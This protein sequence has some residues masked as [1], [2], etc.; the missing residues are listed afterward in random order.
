M[1][2]CE[3]GRPGGRAP[4]TEVASDADRGVLADL[5]AH[6]SVSD[7]W[8][9]PTR[10]VDLLAA[11]RVRLVALTDHDTLDGVAAAAARALDHGVGFVV[12]V[13]IT[14]APRDGM[15]HVLAHGVRRDDSALAALLTRNRRVWRAESLAVLA[16]LR[17]V[18]LR[19]RDRPEYDDPARLLMPHMIARDAVRQGRVRHAEIWRLIDQARAAV[20]ARV[21]AALPDPAETVATVHG[22]GGLAVWAHPGRSA[23]PTAM[24]RSVR[25]FDG[26]E[27]YTPRHSPAEVAELVRLCARHDLPATPGRDFH[28]YPRYTPPPD[29]LDARYLE[30]LADR[31]C[32]PG[33]AVEAGP[34]RPEQAGPGPAID[35][36]PGRPVAPGSAPPDQRR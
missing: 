27:V 13:E 19:L 30:L 8:Y 35:P 34:D 25:A 5:H 15:N 28:G 31:I 20:P 32:W 16:R 22:A 6:S 10:V 17:E 29:V 9:P 3:R 14:V 1:S 7:G 21:Y 18:G 23:D 2:G 24:F 36:R 11:H 33:P 26:V 4:A 12:G